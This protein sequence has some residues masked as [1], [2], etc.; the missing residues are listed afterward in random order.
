MEELQNLE[1]NLTQLN[2]DLK[3]GFSFENFEDNI[4]ITVTPIIGGHLTIK[5]YIRNH[6]YSG[7]TNFNIE[8]DQSY[9]PG[10]IDQVKSLLK[11]INQKYVA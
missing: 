8:T 10:T 9:L 11:E 3:T 6:D 7:S 5:G 1:F 2:L 4:S